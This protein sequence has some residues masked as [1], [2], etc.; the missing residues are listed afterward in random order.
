MGEP[1]RY[2]GTTDAGRRPGRLD[3]GE[4]DVHFDYDER[5]NMVKRSS[6]DD[7]YH[8]DPSY[9]TWYHYED[10]IDPNPATIG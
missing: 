7:P 10:R 8:E 2:P 5:G 6:W 9:S 1:T 4:R 3:E